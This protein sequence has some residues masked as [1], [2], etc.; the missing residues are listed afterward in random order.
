MAKNTVTFETKNNKFNLVTPF[1]SYDVTN[2]T[3]KNI[4]TYIY[5]DTSNNPRF[6]SGFKKALSH[7]LRIS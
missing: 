1:E 3:D 5:I 7:F 2:K 6:S 4:H